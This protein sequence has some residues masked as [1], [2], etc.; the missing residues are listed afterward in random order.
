MAE[1]IYVSNLFDHNFI[2]ALQVFYEIMTKIRL[3][4]WFISCHQTSTVRILSQSHSDEGDE[5]EEPTS[6]TSHALKEDQ[7]FQ[8]TYKDTTG[9]K[10]T[11]PRGHGYMSNPKGKQKLL[12][13]RMFQERLNRLEE[14][15]RQMQEKMQKHEAEKA[16]ERE[17]LKA[18]LR[19]ELMGEFQSML[20]PYRQSM[21]TEQ[22]GNN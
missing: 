18:A 19:Q 6:H 8:Q 15:E 21:M 13:D 22:V 20:A 11:R 10:Y 7:V 1:S 9:A 12:E 17:Q 5:E 16:A 2:S 3:T 14:Q 4:H